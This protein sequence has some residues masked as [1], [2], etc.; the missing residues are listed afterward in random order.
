MHRVGETYGLSE[1]APYDKILVSAAGH[2]IPQELVAQLR[3]GGKIVL[4]VENY[5]VVLAKG[6]NGND[7]IEKY[8][9]FSFVPL[10]RP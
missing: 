9:D 7:I 1:K 6:K 2:D 4:P 3:V 5:I 10:I 8:Y